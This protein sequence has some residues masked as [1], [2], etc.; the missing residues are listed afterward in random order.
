M[1]ETW[2]EMKTW[3]VTKQMYVGGGGGGSGSFVPLRA[4]RTLRKKVLHER[5]MM[6]KT[7]P[8]SPFRKLRF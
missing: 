8:V 5:A 2:L 4:T 7:L 1:R 6:E 3:G